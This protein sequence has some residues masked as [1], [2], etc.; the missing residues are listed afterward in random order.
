MRKLVKRV[1]VIAVVAATGYAVWRW[2]RLNDV[3]TGRT[4][5]Y[6]A[7]R[8]VLY[9]SS[10][11]QVFEAAKQSAA[12]LPGWALGGSG[13]GPAGW[14]LQATHRLPVLP[15]WQEIT[16]RITREGRGARV[17]VRS[18]SRWEAWDFGQNAR[19]IRAFYRALDAELAR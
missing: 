16:I 9:R 4:P 6:A 5:E 1:I 13:S 7:L 15:P 10:P 3:E 12:R 2:P 19:N 18:R 14:T 17:N 11:E 8:P